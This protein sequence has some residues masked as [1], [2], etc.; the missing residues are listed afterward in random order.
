MV[1]LKVIHFL[2]LTYTQNGLRITNGLI[3]FGK[4][5]E[6]G[7]RKLTI[8]ISIPRVHCKNS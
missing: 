4:C 3:K 5:K 8:G 1:L 7:D 2:H 6:I